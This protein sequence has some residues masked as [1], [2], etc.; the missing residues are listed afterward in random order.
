MKKGGVPPDMINLI[1][2][3]LRYGGSKSRGPGLYGD[4]NNIM[5]NLTKSFMTSVQGVQNVY[6]QHVPLVMDTIQSITKGKLGRKTH[7]FV[8]G[9]VKTVPGVSPE[10]L[11]PDEIIVFMVGGVTYE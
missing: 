4:Q 1:P 9:S 3:M 8:P 2:V 7:P 11:I 6:A 5:S 10:T